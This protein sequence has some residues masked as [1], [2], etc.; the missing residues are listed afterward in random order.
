MIGPLR[1]KIKNLLMVKSADSRGVA[2]FRTLLFPSDMIR[3][4]HGVAYGQYLHERTVKNPE[5]NW[6]RLRRNTH[7]IEKGLIMK[8]RRAVFAADYIEETVRD[9][10]N[11]L[12]RLSCG[13]ALS[14]ELQWAHDVLKSYFDVVGSEP[15]VDRA[16]A[17]WQSL[18]PMEFQN[19]V[20]FLRDLDGPC[21]VNYESFYQ[22]CMR[23]RSVRWYEDRPVPR[24]MLDAAMLAATQ[25]P[26]AC[27]RQPFTFRIFDEPELVKKVSKIPMGTKGFA[28]NFPC[29]VVI[30]GELRAYPFAR[31][32][33]VIYID[34]SL[35]AMSFMFA[36]E[37][38]GLASCPINWPDIPE[39][40]EEMA[41]ALN[42]E[43]DERVVMLI[44]V[45]YPDKTGMVPYSGKKVLETIRRY[46]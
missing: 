1:R 36:L 22:L 42:L 35:A 46:N 40:E 39:K 14:D 44:S 18:E 3:E 30:V 33:H 19:Q 12:G 4:I 13:D 41:K 7:R 5:K 26:S 20:P 8:E 24:E 27:N 37:T 6:A 32:R 10:K 45:G 31:D 21:P 9:Y 43:P 29:I 17:M 38:M 34:G 2:L 28:Q 25:S 11:A 16:R 15:R 23:R